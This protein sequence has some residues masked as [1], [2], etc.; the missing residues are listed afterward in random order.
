MRAGIVEFL[1]LKLTPFLLL[2]IKRKK[3]KNKH[4]G[5]GTEERGKPG[6]NRK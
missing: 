4:S 3:K 1:D 6:N 2:I 5:K